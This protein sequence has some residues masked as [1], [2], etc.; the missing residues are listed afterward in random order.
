MDI[1]LIGARKPQVTKEDPCNQAG[2]AAHVEIC[3]EKAVS[4]EQNEPFINQDKYLSAA[5]ALL[6]VQPGLY[7]K[8]LKVS[9]FK[10]GRNWDGIP[11]WSGNCRESIVRKK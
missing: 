10:S 8:G 4:L 1:G 11:S 5:S 6:F 2:G 7:R 9:E 3:P